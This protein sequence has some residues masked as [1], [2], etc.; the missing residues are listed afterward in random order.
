MAETSVTIENNGEGASSEVHVENSV[1]QSTNCV[2]G[3]C[4]T[5][6]HGN[7]Q[8]TVCINGKCETSFNGNIERDENGAKVKVAGPPLTP[9]PTKEAGSSAQKNEASPSGKVASEGAKKTELK[10][11]VEQKSFNLDDLLNTIRSRLSEFF[12]QNR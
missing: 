2:N 1:G 5:T 6:D 7:N 11:K 12:S 9:N 10:Q 3:N 8:A 4:T